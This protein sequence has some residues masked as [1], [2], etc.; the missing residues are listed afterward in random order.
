MR[1]VVHLA[2]TSTQGDARPDTRSGLGP[3]ALQPGFACSQR[4]WPRAWEVGT[5]VMW[6]EHTTG[7]EEGQAGSGAR[8]TM[9]V[10][11]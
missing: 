2:P 10:A 11:K 5:A 7:W 4:W 3:G 1:P 6:I 8:A 9:V